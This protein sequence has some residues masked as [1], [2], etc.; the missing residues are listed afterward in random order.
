MFFQSFAYVRIFQSERFLDVSVTLGL[1]EC[2]G[3]WELERYVST[4]W[5][6]SEYMGELGDS[7]EIR[8]VYLVSITK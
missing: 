5:C 2:S 4:S 6:S 3:P 7:V 1:V 8:I